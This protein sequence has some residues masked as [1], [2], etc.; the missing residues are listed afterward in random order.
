MVRI[1]VIQGLVL[2]PLNIDLYNS[3]FFF[4]QFTL[5]FNHLFDSQSFPSTIYLVTTD[6]SCYDNWQAVIPRC[7][8]LLRPKYDGKYPLLYKTNPFPSADNYQDYDNNVVDLFKRR[9][10]CCRPCHRNY[11]GRLLPHMFLY[12]SKE[13]GK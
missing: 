6:R 3:F 11:L 2:S 5:Q 8:L 10:A 7:P 9:V 13:S 1:H 4:R 12:R